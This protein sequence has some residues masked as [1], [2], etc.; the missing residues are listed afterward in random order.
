MQRRNAP[1]R[2]PRMTKGAWLMVFG[3]FLFACGAAAYLANPNQAPTSLVAG[4][5]GGGIASML[6]VMVMKG[7]PQWAL[8][9][10]NM[11]T[12]VFMMLALAMS[13]QHWMLVYN[14]GKDVLSPVI[15]TVVVLGAAVVL[16]GLKKKA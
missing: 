6:G 13:M 14:G 9:A 3:V 2:L 4:A 7:T 11:L 12:I 1:V 8:A 10:G 16:W 5:I 15:D